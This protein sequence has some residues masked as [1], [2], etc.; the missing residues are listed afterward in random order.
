MT[1]VEMIASLADGQRHGTHSVDATP[2]ASLDRAAAYRIQS[3]VLAAVGAKVG[4]LKTAIH[5]DGIGVAAPIFAAAVGRN[6]FRLPVANV[7][8]LEVEVGVV[9]GKD[10]GA[11][12]D[13][14]SAV[15]HY[16]AGIE[17]VGSRFADRKLAGT[18]GQLADNMS[19]LGYVVGN[20]PRVLRD[21]IDG[22]TV[23]LEFAGK[24]IYS[25]P[26]VHG[27]GTVLA[28]L[29]AYAK[30]QQPGLALKAGTI[31]TTG[32]LC[33]LVLTSGTGHAVAR[34]GNDVVDFD[35]V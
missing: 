6:G 29:A 30:A 16:F 2:F 25:A 7:L 14:A 10:V 19:A 27:F 13:L 4:M 17:I 28:S 11:E 12:T 15:D 31:I 18:N 35:L 9:L 32:S 24:Q 34:L 1:E 26:A 8:G 21:Q 3:S 22:L 20:E 33:G 23:S 5:G